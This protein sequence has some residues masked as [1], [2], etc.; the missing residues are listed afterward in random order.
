MRAIGYERS[1]PIEDEASLVDIDLP[2]P[3]LRGRNI[4]VAVRAVSVN[5]VDT[6]VRVRAQPDPGELEGA[7]LGRVRHRRGGR[8]RRDALQAWRCGV[9]CRRARPSRHERRVPRRRRAHRRPQAVLAVMGRGGR[10]AADRHHGLGSAVRPPRRP[11]ARPGCH[12]RYLDRR[13]RGRCRLD[14]YAARPSAHGSHRHHDRVAAR[15]QGLEPRARRRTTSSTTRSRWRA[16]WKRSASA[17]RRSCSRPRTPAAIS[18]R[19]RS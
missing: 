18:P 3:E 12:E 9:L 14:R 7:R 5:P 11:Q 6:K 15:D 10:F 1:L 13:G 16:R 8:P 17:R 19:S 2:P 4:L